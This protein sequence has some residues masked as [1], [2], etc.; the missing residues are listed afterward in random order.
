MTGE[1]EHGSL[2][3]KPG[4]KI[5]DVTKAHFLNGKAEGFEPAD[6]ELLATLVIRRDGR[7]A[8][9]F[10]SQF[11]RGIGHKYSKKWL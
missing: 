8:N 6:H 7:P 1:T 5:I 11:Y 2:R 4:P 3:A 9:Q 10:Q